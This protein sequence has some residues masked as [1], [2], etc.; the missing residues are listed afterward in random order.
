MSSFKEDILALFDGTRGGHV[1]KYLYQDLPRPDHSSGSRLWHDFVSANKNYYPIAAEISLIPAL[2]A[3]VGGH[4]DTVIDFGIGDDRAV[5]G[6]LKPLLAAQNDLKRYYGIDISAEQLQDGIAKI[7]AEFPHI[8]SNGIQ[9]DFYD[10]SPFIEGDRPLGLL[11]GSTIS[12]QDMLPDEPFPRAQFVNKIA[13]LAQTSRVGNG[14]ELVIS[15][16]ANPDLDAALAAY[17]HPAWQRMMTG[18]MYDVQATL[19]P[20]GNFSP[21][22]WH[23][24]PEINRKHHVLHQIISPSVDQDFSIDGREFKVRR[25]D[26]FVVKNNFKPSAALMQEL[27]EEAKTKAKAI[28]TA[29]NHPMAML[30]VA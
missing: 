10:I 9:G 1:Q 13:R 3:R 6:K 2:I 22:L 19:R 15:F 18:L 14:G 28:I 27:A 11:L 16:D 23:Y 30:D 29:P 24:A 26:R 20:E 5:N 17:Q 7:Q 25:G 12:N 21:S 4:H 8:A